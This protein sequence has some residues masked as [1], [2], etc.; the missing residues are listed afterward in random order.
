MSMYLD[1]AALEQPNIHCNKSHYSRYN[2]Y[3]TG[4]DHGERV[5]LYPLNHT[6]HTNM[7]LSE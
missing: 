1:D 7:E 3:T 4:E 5:D 2:S 6:A